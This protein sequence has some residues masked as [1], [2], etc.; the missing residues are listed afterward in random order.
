MGQ[1][2]YQ[3]LSQEFFSRYPKNTTDFL[4]VSG[5]V[6]P[7]TLNQ[8]NEMPF[9]SKVV[10]GLQKEKKNSDLHKQILIAN[11]S[12]V[13]IFYPG[14]L[15]HAKCYLWLENGTPI[16]GLIGSANFSENG[17]NNDFRETL[18]EVDKRDLHPL[19][20]YINIIADS[21]KLCTE[22]VVE[23]TETSKFSETESGECLL[24]LYDPRT[25]EVQL[26]SGL[27]WGL[28]NGHVQ[29]DDA[30][31]PIRTK[32]ILKFPSLFQPHSFVAKEGHRSRQVNEAAEVIWDD[33]VVMKVLFEQTNKSP[34]LPEPYPKAMSSLPK[35]NILGRYI[36]GRLGLLNVSPKKLDSERITREILEKYGRNTIAL[37]LVSPGLYKA[38]FSV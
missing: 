1:L 21:A 13:Q 25:G 33:G 29:N 31:I 3:N 30:Y 14:I 38:D 9:N 7:T 11:S 20:S 10:F 26:K 4:A 22:V 32:H 15:S 12:K 27:N 5:Y 23:S 24:E 8:L 34:L 17:L 19:R 16:R 36:R 2:Y 6:G 37:S 18:L 35:K 28:S